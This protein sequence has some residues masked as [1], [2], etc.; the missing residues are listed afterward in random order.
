MC[1]NRHKPFYKVGGLYSSSPE[2]IVRYP[3]LFSQRL[4]NS[5][6]LSTRSH[7]RLL[8]ATCTGGTYFWGER[9]DGVLYR[10]RIRLSAF[11]FRANVSVCHC[12]CLSAP[13]PPHTLQSHYSPFLAPQ[14]APEDVILHAHG[15]A[16][17]QDP[18]GTL[19]PHKDWVCISGV[20]ER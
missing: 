16:H 2:R 14:Y 18:T 6:V 17:A 5:F 9:G 4:L 20:W 7:T 13:P 12:M 1:F 15:P 19:I 8:A 10:F 3:L 11:L